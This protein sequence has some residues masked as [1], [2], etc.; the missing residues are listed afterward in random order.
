ME[1]KILIELAQSGDE[2]ALAELID[3]HSRLIWS[4]VK[5]F[6]GRGTD[7]EDLY[8]IGALGFIKCVRRFNLSYDVK[9]STYAVPMILGELKGFFRSDGLVKVSRTLK[10][11]Y[12]K[13]AAVMDGESISLKDAAEKLGINYD[14]AV[15]ALEA[16]RSVESLDSVVGDDGGTTAM[17]RL[18]V[19]DNQEETLINKLELERVF[20]QLPDKSRQIIKMRYFENKTQSYVANQLGISQVQVSRT[21]KKILKFMREKMQ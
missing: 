6:M 14:D 11:N 16:A 4:V 2:T 13:L 21:E 18:I 8:Q 15:L 20:K 12:A 3:K 9:L 10:E 19:S 17:E 7:K 1:D 5:R